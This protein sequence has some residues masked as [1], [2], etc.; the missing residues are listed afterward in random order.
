[1]MP[2]VTRESE[3]CGAKPCHGARYRLILHTFYMECEK[4]SVCYNESMTRHTILSEAALTSALQKLDDWSVLDQKLHAEFTFKDF[5]E[6]IAFIN[7]VAVLAEEHDHHPEFCNS[8][9]KVSFSFCTHDV[10]NQITDTDIKIAARIS[11]A[12]RDVSA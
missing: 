3:Q 8:Y 10:G 2:D 12:A 9:N 5:N 6:A 11:E 1:M 7:S 4:V